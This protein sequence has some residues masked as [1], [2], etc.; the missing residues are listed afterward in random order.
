MMLTYGM[1]AVLL[2]AFVPANAVARSARH[3][4]TMAG[5]STAFY[6][7]FL[8][9]QRKHPASRS[10]PTLRMLSGGGAPKPPEVFLEVR[11]RDA[12]SR[13]CHGYGM[14][15]CPMI[16]QGAP[17]DTDEQLMYTDGA[18]VAG[19]SCRSSTSRARRSPAGVTARCA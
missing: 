13:S 16:T 1:P 14:T 11:G 4:V 12:T 19:A 17:S 15:E 18:P 6:L 7:A 8:N 2:E 3:D 5:G 9:E 10:M